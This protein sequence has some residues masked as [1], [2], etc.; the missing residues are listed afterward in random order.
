M[1]L[2]HCLFAAFVLLAPNPDGEASGGIIR[3][4]SDVTCEVKYQIVPEGLKLSHRHVTATI[5]ISADNTWHQV[6][7]NFEKE[8]AQVSQMLTVPVR[9]FIGSF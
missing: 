6:Y 8:E 4:A 1:I 2:T 7:Y 9:R 3:V 5:P